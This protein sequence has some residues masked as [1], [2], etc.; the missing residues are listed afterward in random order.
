MASPPKV[1]KLI[2]DIKDDR[3]NTPNQSGFTAHRD[4]TKEIIV[5]SV[6]Q[7][8]DDFEFEGSSGQMNKS[9]LIPRPS[10]FQ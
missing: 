1:R 7:V 6:D 2:K 3:V 10:G 8:D 9:S 5:Q 4:M